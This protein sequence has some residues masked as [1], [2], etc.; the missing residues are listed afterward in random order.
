[1]NKEQLKTMLDMQLEF[2]KS[3]GEKWPYRKYLLAA[4]METSEGIDHT[5]WCWWKKQQYDLP[6]LQMELVDIWHFVISY[7]LS[8]YFASTGAY[9][10]NA[11]VNGDDEILFDGCWYRFDQMSTLS[12]LRLFSAMAF[13]DKVNVKLFLSIIKDC[14]LS[15]DDLYKMYI[16]KNVLN[17]FRQDHGY[18]D[19]H[20]KKDWDD[21]EDNVYL[22]SILKPMN[23]DCDI[24][25]LRD[26]I[27]RSLEAKYEK[28]LATVTPYNTGVSNVK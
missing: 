26:Q 11:I 22:N 27:Y 13:V 24:D 23:H 1:M 2:N 20:Y 14:H 3:L 6:Q 12:K 10:M 21:T 19:D 8:Q 4:A 9:L 15:T 25:L 17:K 16:G 28:V 18:K 5:D 7:Y